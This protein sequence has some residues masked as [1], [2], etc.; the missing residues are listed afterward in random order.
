VSGVS[1]W[2]VADLG[3]VFRLDPVLSGNA[4]VKHS[5]CVF[6]DLTQFRAA[7]VCIENAHCLYASTRD[8]RG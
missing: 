6:C 5:D 7:E 4:L 1:A 3:T 8:P 2:R